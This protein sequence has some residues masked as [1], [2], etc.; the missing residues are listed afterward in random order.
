MSTSTY[1]S[2]HT[3]SISTYYSYP[4]NVYLHLLQLSHKCLSPL[5]TVITP[6]LSLLVLTTVF[7]QMFISTYYSYHTM[8]I[9]TSTYYSYPTNVY[10]HLLQLSHQCL[11]Q[12]T[13]L[14]TVIPQMS[15]STYYS[16]PTYYI[17]HSC[18][19]HEQ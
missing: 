3:M 1:Y 15:T 7:P 19:Q 5:T 12:P 8:S 17:C 4:T 14:T 11:P 2:Y 16:H 18:K 10:L 6:C 13:M 9:S